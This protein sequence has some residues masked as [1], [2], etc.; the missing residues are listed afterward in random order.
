MPVV[1]HCSTQRVAALYGLDGKMITVCVIGQKYPVFDANEPSS[2]AGGALWT[3][4]TIARAEGL[5]LPPDLGLF[6]PVVVRASVQP[7]VALSGLDVKMIPVRGIEILGAEQNTYEPP[8]AE[9][10]PA[11]RFWER[12]KR[13]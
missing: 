4:P 3:R 1:V 6:M 8:V 12:S 9:A 7:I 2:T 13:T 10:V 11:A 5:H